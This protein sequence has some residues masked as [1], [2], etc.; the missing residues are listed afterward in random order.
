M[1]RS[2]SAG[3]TIVCAN[4][5]FVNFQFNN[6]FSVAIW[7]YTTSLAAERSLVLSQHVAGPNAYQGW[8]LL[9]ETTGKCRFNFISDVSPALWLQKDTTAAISINNWFNF[10]VTYDGSS[11]AAGTNMYLNGSV[12]NGAVGHDN[13]DS[14]STTHNTPMRFGTR[15]DATNQWLGRMADCGIWNVV[16]TP[17]EVSAL[18]K[19]IL[20][21][22]IRKSSLVSYHPLDGLQS[23]E[24]DLSGNANNGTL[25]GTAFVVGPPVMQFTPRWPMGSILPAPSAAPPLFADRNLHAFSRRVVPI[26]Y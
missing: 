10:C 6:P 4:N 24:P 9:V 14:N 17:T 18:G 16:L 26:G 21:Y 1:G 5:T 3:N 15:T 22:T 11:L 8:E 2:F 23:P 12:S 7:G 25:T 20:P 19:G 13:L